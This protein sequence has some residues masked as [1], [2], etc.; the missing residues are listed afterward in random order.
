[1]LGR[2]QI[3]YN[4]RQRRK[5]HLELKAKREKIHKMILQGKNNDS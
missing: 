4:R 2:K 3:G 1:M 5:K